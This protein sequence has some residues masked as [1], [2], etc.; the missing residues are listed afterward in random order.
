MGPP[1]WTILPLPSTPERG[2]SCTYIALYLEYKMPSAVSGEYFLG[3]ERA[4][5]S[6]YTEDAST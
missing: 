3:Y 1:T 6:I 5:R 2:P 4:A